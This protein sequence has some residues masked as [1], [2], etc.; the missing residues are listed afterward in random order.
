[1]QVGGV[2]ES[3]TGDIDTYTQEK[4]MSAYQKSGFEIRADLLNQAQAL[5]EQN[6]SF[7]LDAYH[8]RVERSLQ[9]RDIPYPDFPEDCVEPITV[10]QIILTAQ[11]LNA[12]VKEQ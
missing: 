9:Q 1:M 7:K 5:L 10:D 2:L 12:F 11:E 8:N 3:P 6:R 4:I